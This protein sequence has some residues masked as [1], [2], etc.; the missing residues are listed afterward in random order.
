MAATAEKRL[1]RDQQRALYAY[2]VVGQVPKD[3]QKDYKI[4]VNDLAP[5]S[6]AV[7]CVRP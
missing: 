7:A 2:T 5:T 6:C 4:A 1:F 3:A